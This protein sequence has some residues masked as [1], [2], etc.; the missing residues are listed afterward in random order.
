MS[1]AM[2]DLL[3][4]VGNPGA[5]LRAVPRRLT[6]QQRLDRA[7]GWRRLADTERLLALGL[8]APAHVQERTTDRYLRALGVYCELFDRC[9]AAEGIGVRHATH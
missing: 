3:R 6:L 8:N 5:E 7:D 1:A 2:R 4:R 9:C